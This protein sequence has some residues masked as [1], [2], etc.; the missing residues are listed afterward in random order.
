MIPVTLRNMSDYF[1]KRLILVILWTMS[2]YFFLKKGVHTCGTVTGISEKKLFD[3]CDIGDQGRIFAF[4]KKKH[5]FLVRAL[6]LKFCHFFD[7]ID[8][9]LFICICEFTSEYSQHIITTVDFS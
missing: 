1:E 7:Q 4:E 2:E 5:L 3:T 9:Y 6:Q 8:L